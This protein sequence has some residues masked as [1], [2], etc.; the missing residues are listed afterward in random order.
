M[1]MKMLGM[2]ICLGLNVFGVNINY[3][4]LGLVHFKG[5]KGF[6]FE[7]SIKSRMLEQ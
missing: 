1:L 6:E 3:V 2:L 5:I 7:V 4:C